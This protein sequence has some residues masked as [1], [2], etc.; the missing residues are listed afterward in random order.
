PCRQTLRCL[1]DPFERGA[2]LSAWRLR[3][4][5]AS[6]PFGHTRTLFRSH[7]G[8]SLAPEVEALDGAARLG[9]PPDERDRRVTLVVQRPRVRALRRC[10]TAIELVGARTT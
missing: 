5:H 8:L 7:G 1:R 10:R 3:R 6:N 2:E 4:T 9:Q